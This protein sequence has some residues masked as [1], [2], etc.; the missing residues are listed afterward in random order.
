MEDLRHLI[1]DIPDFPKKGILF[2]DITPLLRDRDAFKKAV[3]NITKLF[4]EKKIDLVA[5]VEARG[6]ILGGAIAYKLGAG[7]VP[8]RK[9]G[10][11]P[12]RTKRITYAL[13]Y[14]EDT[15]ELHEDA[16][17]SG[18]RVLVVDDLLATGGTS[19][20]V[21]ELVKSLGGEVVGTVFL[22]EL[23]FLKGREKL[24]GHKVSSLLSF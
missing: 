5:C 24:K 20:A 2:K 8:I 1:R 18:E 7:F 12:Y 6:F 9:K 23:T 19:A 15:L 14:G 16:I 22:V 21:L 11:L 17:R 4:S 3:D 10:K 13:E